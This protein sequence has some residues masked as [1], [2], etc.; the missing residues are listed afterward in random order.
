MTDGKAIK[1]MDTQDI[2]SLFGNML[3]NALDYESKISDPAKRFISLTIKAINNKVF[4]HCENYFV[5]ENFNSN[6]FL[7]TDKPDKENHGFGTKSM[8][9]IVD[10]YKGTINLFIADKMFQVDCV[11]PIGKGKKE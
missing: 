4:I 3:D 9:K 8:G 5:E 10:K 1:F 2:Y 6:N 7:K 11:I